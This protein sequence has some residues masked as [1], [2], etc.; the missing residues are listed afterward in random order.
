MSFLYLENNVVKITDEGMAL[1]PYD[2]LY[3]SDK[4]EGKKF[5]NQVITYIYWVFK[6]DG[7]YSNQPLPSRKKH[8]SKAYINRNYKELER[9][10]KVRECIEEYYNINY[11][12]DERRLDT[13]EN[14]IDEYMD[15]LVSIPWTI[16]QNV[17]VDVEVM[18]GEDKQ[19]I[20]KKVSVDVPNDDAKKKS[21]KSLKEMIE[22]RNELEKTIS[23]QSRKKRDSG[24]RLF[25]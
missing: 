13:V 7:I 4:T 14:D 2:V 12:R 9:Q 21:M 18:V 20:P 23:K 1:K 8:V 10:P 3:K 22:L 24:K 16:R 15:Y 19:I 17:E 25:D 11:T 6:K 5:F